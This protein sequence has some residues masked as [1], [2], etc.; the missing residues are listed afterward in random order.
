LL[1]KLNIM[2]KS[3]AAAILVISIAA[4]QN[5][6]QQPEVKTAPALEQAGNTQNATVQ[7]A[8]AT[9]TDLVC[10]MTV[11]AGSCDTTLYQ[12]KIY[13]FCSVECKAEFNNN[14]IAF[15]KQ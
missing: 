15:L 3:L 13:G 4:C 12:D 11:E 8:L 14:P 9:N 7:F 2:I 6:Q 5:K 10:G 1:D